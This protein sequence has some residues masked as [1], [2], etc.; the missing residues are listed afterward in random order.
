MYFSDI[1]DSD[2]G[3]TLVGV[4]LIMVND[5]MVEL[6]RKTRG[7]RIRLLVNLIRKFAADISVGNAGL[8]S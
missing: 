1:L 3:E 4:L 7:K 2:V 8:E 5:L 6:E